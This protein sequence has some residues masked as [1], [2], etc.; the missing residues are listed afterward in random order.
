MPNKS[1]TVVVHAHAE[2]VLG[3]FAPIGY[4]YASKPG[5]GKVLIR[6]E[7]LA[8]IVAQGLDG[9]ASGRFQLRAEV[10]RFFEQFQFQEFPKNAKGE[11][12][13]ELVNR[14]LSRGDLC[15]SYPIG[16]YG[17]VLASGTE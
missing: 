3:P 12:S 15:R 5:H 1:A 10:K 7:P 6:N 4:K 11:V 8:S 9:F 13:N 16:H 2:W 14:I 17:C